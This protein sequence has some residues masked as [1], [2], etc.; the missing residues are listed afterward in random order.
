MEGLFLAGDDGEAIVLDQDEDIASGR[1]AGTVD[2]AAGTD[3][4]RHVKWSPFAWL[5]ENARS[6]ASSGSVLRS[7]QEG[8]VRL[9]EQRGQWLFP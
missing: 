2:E 6:T 4:E 8:M 9:Q 7:W 5:C 3:G 1:L